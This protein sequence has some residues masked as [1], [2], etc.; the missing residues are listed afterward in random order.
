MSR[1]LN[2]FLICSSGFSCRSSYRIVRRYLDRCFRYIS[3]GPHL[4]MILEQKYYENIIHFTLN[5]L[6]CNTRKS[7]IRYHV[8]SVHLA[9][10]DAGEVAF[11]F[12]NQFH[13]FMSSKS[14]GMSVV[15][16]SPWRL[17]ARD[18]SPDVGKKFSILPNDFI[19]AS[20]FRVFIIRL[21]SGCISFKWR[22]YPK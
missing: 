9:A 5:S 21:I 14:A 2:K 12:L 3:K 19:V 13:H 8:T 1:T 4:D 10:M 6:P 18:I 16:C 20:S 15:E 17:K 11:R 7:I 22:K